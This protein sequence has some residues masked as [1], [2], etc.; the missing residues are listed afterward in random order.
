MFKQ[1]SLVSIFF[2]IISVVLLLQG[3][4][5][6]PQHAPR[7]NTPSA[8]FEFTRFRASPPVDLNKPP[9]FLPEFIPVHEDN[10]E[11]PATSSV[12]RSG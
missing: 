11:G 9:V 1:C 5:C 7:R 4:E 8:G 10:G 3:F 2:A 12:Y 6:S